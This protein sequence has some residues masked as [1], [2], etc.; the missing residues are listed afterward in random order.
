MASTPG[1]SLREQRMKCDIVCVL[2]L[3]TNSV[4]PV[5]SPRGTAVVHVTSESG[6]IYIFRS[7]N[8]RNGV[9]RDFERSNSTWFLCF[10]YEPN[11]DRSDNP[12]F[13]EP[14]SDLHVF[15]L[16]FYPPEV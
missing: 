16:F 10:Q 5:T 4:F 7:H 12:S 6:Q 13:Q 1:A 11:R 8:V 3:S 14:E 2:H 9:M 15:F